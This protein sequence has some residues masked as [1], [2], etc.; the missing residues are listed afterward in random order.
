[1]SRYSSADSLVR[2][3]DKI[4]TPPKV[5]HRVNEI[6]SDPNSTTSDIAH[7]ISG[8]AGISLRLLRIVN[9]AFFG[10][11]QKVESLDQ[12][13]MA[14]GTAQ[15][16]DLVLA[17]TVAEKFE[18]LPP[19]LINMDR[20]WAHS[21][22]CGV[23]ARSLAVARKEMV[24]EPFFLAGMMHDVGRLVMF[25]KMPNECREVVSRCLK[26]NEV[27]QVV[28]REVFGFDHSDVGGCLLNAWG[29]PPQLEEAVASH[30]LPQKAVR[31]PML[32]SVVHIADVVVHALKLGNSGV[33]M[34]PKLSSFA[35]SKFGLASHV[36]P[37]VV[38]QTELQYHAILKA[39]D[40][41]APR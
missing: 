4:A 30:H 27:M 33:N 26:N 38:E 2:S 21:L 32:S 34:I 10:Y 41:S 11:T 18:G 3:A 13:V 22:A 35:W 24:L 8:D 1:M 19:D 14:V 23:T 37:A 12:A 5:Y 40:I 16:R 20:F 36:L 17:T 31:N 39:M 28:E 29:L 15:V 7:V 9:S 6:V 25:T